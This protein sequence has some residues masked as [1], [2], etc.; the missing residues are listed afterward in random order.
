MV[1]VRFARPSVAVGLGMFCRHVLERQ[2][3]QLSGTRGDRSCE[4]RSGGL[5]G[6]VYGRKVVVRILVF[7][8]AERILD[9]VLNSSGEHRYPRAHHYRHPLG[10]E[11]K[12]SGVAPR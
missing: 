5:P 11:F 9:S 8:A 10:I 4:D 6:S 12:N 2:L 7:S 1:E 3:G